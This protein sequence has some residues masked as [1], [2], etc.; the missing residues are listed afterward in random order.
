MMAAGTECDATSN[1]RPVSRLAVVAF[2]AGCTS[3]LV[4]ITPLAAMLP[5]VAIALAAAALADIRRSEGHTVGRWIALAGLALAVGFASQAAS[6]ALTETMIVRQRAI[7]TAT[8][9]VDAVRTGRVADAIAVSS[10]RALPA[11]VDT[12]HGPPP[13]P[14]VKVEA[15]REMPAVKAVAAC[16]T[17]ALTIAS[18]DRAD[19]GWLIRISLAGCGSSGDLLIF[20]APRLVTRAGRAVEEWLVNDLRLDAGGK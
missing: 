16:G 17:T 9:W 20:V 6:A 15:F 3:S 2:A 10:Q 4:L 5:I 7:A 18:V 14:E 19:D 13:G 11:G 12:R 8:A 1:Y